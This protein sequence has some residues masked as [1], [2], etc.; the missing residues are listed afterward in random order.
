[1]QPPP[2]EVV[3]EDVPPLTTPPDGRV[4]EP[5]A[6]PLRTM[7]VGSVPPWAVSPKVTDLAPAVVG[8]KVSV[9]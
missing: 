4:E 2:D 6:V 7:A 5:R 3:A 8:A 1:M 9:T